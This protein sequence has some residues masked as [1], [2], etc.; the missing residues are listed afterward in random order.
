MPFLHL[1]I[2]FEDSDAPTPSAIEE[3]LDRAKDWFRYAP[4][5]WIIYTAQDAKY[6]SDKLRGLPGME[7]HAT[8]LLVEINPEKRAGWMPKSFW[9]WLKEDRVPVKK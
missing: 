6:W 7:G 2:Q 8:M 4:N 1:G 5:C 9:K 3:L